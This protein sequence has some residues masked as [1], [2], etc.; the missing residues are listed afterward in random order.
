MNYL[1][2][3]VAQGALCL[4]C[5][6]CKHSTFRQTDDIPSLLVCESC[7]TNAPPA[8]WVTKIIRHGD[9]DP[10]VHFLIEHNQRGFSVQ[11]NTDRRGMESV[12]SIRFCTG[13]GGP[14]SINVTLALRDIAVAVSDDGYPK[15]RFEGFGGVLK[16]YQA[17]SDGDMWAKTDNVDEDVFSSAVVMFPSGHRVIEHLENLIVAILK[18]METCPTH[19]D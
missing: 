7:S 10:Y 3:A 4:A 9:D 6:I 1:S 2:T 5:P 18:D 17:R 19:T 13:G 16:I 15:A 12:E 8:G 14:K 11:V